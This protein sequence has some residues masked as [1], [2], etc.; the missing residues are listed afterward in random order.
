MSSVGPRPRWAA[1]TDRFGSRFSK[2]RVGVCWSRRV[3]GGA[4]A[5]VGRGYG[6]VRFSV[7]EAAGRGLLESTCRRWG[8]GH[9]GP[10]LRPGSVLGSRSGGS[11]F[12][13]VDVSSVGPRPR[14]AAATARFGSRF[15]R[16]RVGVCWSRR[17]VGGAAATA[18][19]GY[20]Q[21]RFSVL[22]AAGRGLLGSTCRRWGRGHG[23]PRL[24]PGSVLGSRGGGSG[25][26]GVDVSSVGPRPRWAAAT[27]RFGSRFS[28]RRVGVCWSRRVVGGVAATAGRGY[29]QVRFSVLEAA[30]RGL[31]GSTCRRW[32]RGHGG[33]RLRPRSGGHGGAAATPTGRAARR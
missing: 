29:G 30:G 26:A 24:R 19:R 28:K 8:R 32:G 3:V 4:A 10:R 18:G 16:R 21:V 25:F 17:V 7:L 14:W 5:T 31:L 15:S 12:A 6:Q 33:T 9:G 13:G 23:G 11:G 20:G 2:R 27:A 1:A 22:E